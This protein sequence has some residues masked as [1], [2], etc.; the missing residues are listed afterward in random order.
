ML[1]YH[2]IETNMLAPIGAFWV[3]WGPSFDYVVSPSS[4]HPDLAMLPKLL[5]AAETDYSLFGVGF[6]AYCEPTMSLRP[7]FWPL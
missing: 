4:H 7:I 5:T 3:L 6:D 2:V 1:A